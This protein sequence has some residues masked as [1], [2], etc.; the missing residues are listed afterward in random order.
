MQASA[1]H[2]LPHASMTAIKS[3]QYLMLKPIINRL[4][5]TKLKTKPFLDLNSKNLVGHRS[6]P[7]DLYILEV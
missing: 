2:L 4:K 5:K 7:G 1:V 3:F 6:E